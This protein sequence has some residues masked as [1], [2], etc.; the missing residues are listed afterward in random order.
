MSFGSI[1]KFNKSG[2]YID[3]L[4][5]A[6]CSGSLFL[7]R[8]PVA[9]TD[10]TTKIL[11]KDWLL[12][13]DLPPVHTHTYRAFKLFG[14][15]GGGGFEGILCDFMILCRLE[16]YSGKAILLTKSPLLSFMRTPIP[17]HVDALRYDCAGIDELKHL[18]LRVSRPEH[19]IN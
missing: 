19:T 5:I 1:D 7:L 15:V 9:T 11:S 6:R 12:A 17:K 8:I 18:V 4:F 10:H 16:Y 14:S 3:P 13:A 2:H